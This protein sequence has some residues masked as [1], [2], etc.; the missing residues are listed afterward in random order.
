MKN[1]TFASTNPS[2]ARRRRRGASRLFV[3]GAAFM[4]SAAA[5]GKLTTPVYA[6]STLRDTRHE[7]P[8]KGVGI[9]DVGVAVGGVHGRSL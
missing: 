4:A 5:S 6:Q 8:R 1:R 7:I 2:R 9:R 3:L